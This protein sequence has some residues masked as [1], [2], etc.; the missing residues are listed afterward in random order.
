MKIEDFIK[1]I[2]EQFEE[3]K[4]G[5]LQ[6]DSNFREVFEWNSINALIIIAMINTEY[7]VTIDAED[8]RKSNTVQD[9][10][11]IIESRI[12]K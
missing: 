3:L 9:I 1:L 10:F 12:E 8:I 11:S 6:P 2:E 7:G 5:V 4:P